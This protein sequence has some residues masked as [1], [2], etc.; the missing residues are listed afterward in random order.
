MLLAVRFACAGVVHIQG[1]V[2]NAG[3][4]NLQCTIV[5]N[6]LHAE[7]VGVV[8]PLK[9]GRFDR[10]L[11]ISGAA[12]LSFSDGTNHFGGLVEP[13]DSI[14]IRYDRSDFANSISYSGTGKDKFEITYSIGQIK[15]LSRTALA[16]A[17]KQ[18]FPV[19]YMFAAIDSLRDAVGARIARSASSMRGESRM[20]LLGYLS[21]TELIT[22]HNGLA[23]IF[24]DSFN[25]IL[26]NHKDQLSE[27]SVTRMHELLRFDD[28]FYNSRLYVDALT[29]IASIYLEEN[30]QPQTSDFPARKYQL[31]ADLLP[32]KLRSPVIYQTLKSDVSNST[33]NEKAVLNAIDQLTD[34]SLKQI[35]T[36]LLA[37]TKLLRAGDMAPAFSMENLAGEKV[38]LESFRGKTV[39]LDFWFASCGPCHLLFKSIEPVKKRFENDDRVVFLTVSVDN[40]QTWK[41]A[42]TKFGVKG[43]H[44][45]T[46]NKLREHPIIKSYNVTGYPTTYIIDPAGRFHSIR[47]SQNPDMLAAQIEESLGVSKK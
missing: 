10:R 24:G 2:S 18:R 30:I 3:D 17:K 12:F 42:I 20:Q 26:S 14:T 1:T 41:K 27:A 21:A 13:G 23:G 40:Q 35:I 9:E 47:P 46:E 36:D 31:L 4:D 37:G 7:R 11:E 43:Y 22:K 44:V 5:P 16:A 45:F 39:Y 6:A 25:N 33:G 32:E 29:T 34:D 19:D 28:A 15:I 38:N 8:I